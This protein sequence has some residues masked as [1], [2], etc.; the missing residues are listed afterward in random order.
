MKKFHTERKGRAI[1]PNITMLQFLRNILAKANGFD[2]L[3]R[4]LL[5]AAP[6]VMLAGLLLRVTLIYWLGI[7]LF[8]YFY[9]RTFSKNRQ[10]FYEQNRAFLRYK[11]RFDVVWRDWKGAW[12]K[13][14]NRF[15]QRKT[16]RFYRCPSCG[17][18][19]RIPKGRGKV[20]ITCPS[21]RTKFVKKS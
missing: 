19:V 8:L 15:A 20:T 9:I 21:C 10:R 16:H 6:I 2:D 14:R 1:L 12:Q 5:K 3:S 11:R 13:R 17:Q 4:F 18:Q 7:A